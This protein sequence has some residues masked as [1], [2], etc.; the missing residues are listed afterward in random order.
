MVV[1][2][3]EICQIIVRNV[4]D[5]HA[6]NISSCADK[7]QFYAENLRWP[8]AIRREPQEARDTTLT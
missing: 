2:K 8:D 1:S 6:G 4:N 7:P 5:A 3:N